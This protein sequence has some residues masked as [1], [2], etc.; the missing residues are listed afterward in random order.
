MTSTLAPDSRNLD[1]E[2]LDVY[3]VKNFTGAYEINEIILYLTAR[4][5]HVIGEVDADKECLTA[6]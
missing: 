4:H 1:I 3:E 6:A 2:G 5:M